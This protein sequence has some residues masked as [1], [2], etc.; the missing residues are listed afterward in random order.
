MAIYSSF[1]SYQ[2]IVRDLPKALARKAAE[3]VV[4]RDIARFT[5]AAAGIR[6]VDD[7]FDDDRT[8]G[9]AVKAY[10]MDELAYARALMRRV[11]SEGTG[12]ESY[13]GKMSDSRYLDLA[14]AFQVGDGGVAP[15]VLH[16]SAL[17]V[18]QRYRDNLDNIGK[19]IGK[20]SSEN[21]DATILEYRIE[22]DRIG[23]FD[24]F[25]ASDLA[26]TFTLNAFGLDRQ[27]FQL[28]AVRKVVTDEIAARAAGG[29]GLYISGLE[30]IGI[31]DAE[32]RH[33][34]G[35]FFDALMASG[36][37]EG[38]EAV[39]VG[40]RL[41]APKLGE[42]LAARVDDDVAAFYDGL[43]AIKTADDL[44][45]NWQVLSIGLRAFDLGHLAGQEKAI[46][47]ALKGDT[48]ALPLTSTKDRENFEAFKAVFAFESDGTPTAAP[49]VRDARKTVQ[50]YIRQVLELDV[51]REDNNVRLALNFQRRAA[52]IKSAYDI[53]ADEAL[54]AVIRT[55]FGIPAES[56]AADI[57]A[58]ARLITSQVNIE[59]FQD[60]E[61]VEKLIRRF[62]L[63]ADVEAGANSPM[64]SLFYD[65]GPVD[66]TEDLLQARQA[67]VR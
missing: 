64:L 42:K 30:T 17:T 19:N 66:I 16:A 56:A 20:Q 43:D 1:L 2:A 26:L 54:A 52:E 25:L 21:I 40:Y 67:L 38:R 14:G 22:M 9:F 39:I 62:L 37:E 57:D 28:D 60:P 12:S 11:V 63:L 24:A 35:Q 29:A 41:E 7:L 48:R 8:Y 45:G 55:A 34:F 65:S 6:T 32:G 31:T 49:L 53:L 5:E 46:V 27:T 15:P 51:G 4:A 23:S 58:Q 44:A 50:A 47:A 3:P 33:K 13:A 61:K 59:D 36:G 18:S 10:G